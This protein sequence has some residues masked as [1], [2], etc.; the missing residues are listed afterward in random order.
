LTK[1][2]SDRR[3]FTL[4]E[5]MIVVTIIGILAAIAVPNYQWS[6][7]KAKEA[8]LAESLYN[9]NNCLDQFFAD[10]G[11]YPGALN[12]LVTEKYLRELPKD[13]FTKDNTS[14]VYNPPPSTEGSG[15]SQPTE[16]PS[17]HSGSNLVG[18]NGVPYNEWPR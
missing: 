11:K 1:R 8:V 13:P 6:V 16:I 14:W 4:I 17:V 5:L 10:K 12:D 18:T 9:L 7:I 15:T 3:G 2:V